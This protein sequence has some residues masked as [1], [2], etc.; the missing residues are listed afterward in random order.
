M[1]DLQLDDPTAPRCHLGHRL[2]TTSASR[3][4]DWSNLFPGVAAATVEERKLRRDAAHHGGPVSHSINATL[5][6]S[7]VE[8]FG[9]ISAHGRK[10]L[11]MW[12]A[13]LMEQPGCVPILRGPAAANS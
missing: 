8:D 4:N 9:C 11:E 6:P 5:I 10:A 3:F 2:A 1:I 12:A 13:H 7:V